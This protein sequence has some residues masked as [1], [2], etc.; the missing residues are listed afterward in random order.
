MFDKLAEHLRDSA[1]C[2]SRFDGFDRGDTDWQPEPPTV[3]CIGRMTL[4]YGH[5]IEIIETQSDSESFFEVFLN[6]NR[7]FHVFDDR[8]QAIRVARWWV[9]GCPC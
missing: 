2:A 9:D 7:V 6:G 8:A 3:R 5:R 4:E 1:P